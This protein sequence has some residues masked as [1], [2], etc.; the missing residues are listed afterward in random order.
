M[1]AAVAPCA[2]TL[3]RP[4]R[5]PL[6][7]TYRNAQRCAVTDDARRLR[8]VATS[9]RRT[10]CSQ[11]VG[12]RIETRSNGCVAADLDLA[13]VMMNLSG[14]VII[15]LTDP[16]S[17]DSTTEHQVIPSVLVDNQG[18]R[19]IDALLQGGDVTIKGGVLD[20]IFDAT[21]MLRRMVST[22]AE[23]VTE[24]VMPGPE[25]DLPELGRLADTAGADV[26]TFLPAINR[27]S[28]T[29][30]PTTATRSPGATARSTSFRTAPL[31]AP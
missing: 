7:E 13:K 3:T 15:R 27:A 25:A 19:L 31:P 21:T 5:I 22:L 28:I 29:V 24:G 1:I 14:T 11:H 17:E 18:R 20:L 8:R 26:S 4:L 23:A 30:L 6:R 9:V 12:A 16:D 10:D 2:Y